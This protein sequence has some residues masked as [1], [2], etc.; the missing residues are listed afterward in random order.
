MTKLE[1]NALSRCPLNKGYV[2]E[3]Y[4]LAKG[5]SFHTTQVVLESH[6]RLRMEVEGA[7]KLLE[8]SQAE[9]QALLRQIAN[10]E[11]R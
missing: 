2:E 6:E 1:Q 5:L 8:E 10:G 9:V 11:A 4:L 3:L 7:T